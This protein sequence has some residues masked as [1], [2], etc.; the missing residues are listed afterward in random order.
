MTHPE[1]G[2]APPVLF[3]QLPRLA[4]ADAALY[5]TYGGD[6]AMNM[7]DCRRVAQATGE[8]WGPLKPIFPTAAGRMSLERVTEMREFYGRDVIFILGSSIQRQKE[9]L[10]EACRKFIREIDRSTGLCASA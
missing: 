7:D 9:G 4:G 6:Y 10:V 2:I 3:G 8:H 5:P 1:N